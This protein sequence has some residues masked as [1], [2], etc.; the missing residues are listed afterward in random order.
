MTLP[1]PDTDGLV[2]A[3]APYPV[4]L[5]GR[6]YLVDLSQ[7]NFVERTIPLLRNQTDISTEQ[8]Q[9]DASLNPEDLVRRSVETCHLGAGQNHR[10]R[11]GS[12]PERFRSS[13]GV[14]VWT[15]WQISLL[16]E[17]KS[18][19]TLTTNVYDGVISVGTYL[20]LADGNNIYFT[21]SALTG[22]PTW[23]TVTGTPAAA[24]VSICSDGYNVYAA[25]GASGVYT[26]TAG[27]AAATSLFTG[28][29]SKVLFLKDRLYTMNGGGVLTNP[30]DFTT[31]PNALPTA[32]LDKGSTWV[33]NSGCAGNNHVYFS[34][35]SNSSDHSVIYKTAVK[36]DGTAMDTPTV[37]ATLPDG[38]K[39]LN[40]C[41]YLGFVVIGVNVAAISQ[42]AVRLAQVQSD[43]NLVLGPRLPISYAYVFAFEPQ[44]RFVYCTWT[45][46]SIQSG[47]GRL[48][49]SRFTEP[50][51]PAFAKDLQFDG[52]GLNYVTGICTHQGKTV[53]RVDAQ[54]LV[55]VDS[56]NL[57]PYG[58]IY[59]GRVG[60]GLLDSKVAMYVDVDMLTP[61]TVTVYVSVDGGARTQYGSPLSASGT[62]DL[63][64]LSGKEFEV[65]L[66]LTRSSG[67]PS[68]GPTVRRVTMRA[69]I[70]ATRTREFLIP[71]I[72]RPRIK[73]MVGQEVAVPDTRAE[74]D[75][76]NAM[77]GTVVVWKY[78]TK[79]E[80]VQIKDYQWTPEYFDTESGQFGG[81]CMVKAQ[82]VHT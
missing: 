2:G 57:K 13:D 10:D 21:N 64:A 78:G 4:S 6:E 32:L 48:D 8:V 81:I 59:F 24:C 29:I 38:E 42:G 71:L 14:D 1:T 56:A 39:V 46:T 65:S 73:T 70:S 23:T 66:R 16:S 30:T 62:I 17:V 5:G 52:T 9:S 80:Y 41:G 20:Y 68:T 45:E 27:A 51:T 58:D 28:T 74:V 18:I 35:S 60:Y 33:W 22:A 76:I 72:I 7:G 25:F 40:M 44:D 43:G 31:P 55:C 61:G 53:F 36:P 63:S 69:F 34:G 50:L 12:V 67:A 54:N 49:L 3:G 79:T 15:Q 19:K 82:A 75:A 77:V 47:I 11:V 26:T 37:A